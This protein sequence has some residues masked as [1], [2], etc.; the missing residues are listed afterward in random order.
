MKEGDV[1]M[2]EEEGMEQGLTA[3]KRE[4]V[5]WRGG[6]AAVVINLRSNIRERKI[7]TQIV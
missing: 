4:A 6:K 5:G 7:A 1:N 3:R 2:M